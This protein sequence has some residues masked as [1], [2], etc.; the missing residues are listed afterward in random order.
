MRLLHLFRAAAVAHMS[1]PQGQNGGG[2]LWEKGL[3]R[4]EAALGVGAS[5]GSLFLSPPES[6]ATVQG[7]GS[8]MAYAVRADGTKSLSPTL[9][10]VNPV[11]TAKESLAAKNVKAVFLG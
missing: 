4:R 9:K 3:S 1:L 6:R 2:G 5:V 10:E 11:K 8:S 7:L